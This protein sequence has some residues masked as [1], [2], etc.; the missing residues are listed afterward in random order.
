MLVFV[1]VCLLSVTIAQVPKPCISPSQWEAH[2]HTTN[3]KLHGE[4]FGQLTYDSV[5]QRTR[6]LQD[7]KVDKTETYY[8]I[9]TLYQAKL[10]FYIDMKTG[11]CSRMPFDQPWRDYGI[12]SDT[13]FASEAYI[14][15]SGIP[16]DGLLVT[17][18]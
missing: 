14:G 13:K 18:W 8:D 9:I 3:W 7:V 2:V 6:I 17:S 16:S 11:T 5:Y 4:L 12:Q 10:S 15:S 1:I